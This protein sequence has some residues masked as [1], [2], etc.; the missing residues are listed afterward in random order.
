MTTNFIRNRILE[1]KENFK[2]KEGGI[3]IIWKPIFEKLFARLVFGKIIYK[4]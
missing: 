4:I 3:E 2:M 1:P